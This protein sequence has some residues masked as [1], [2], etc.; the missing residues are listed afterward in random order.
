[1]IFTDAKLARQLEPWLERVLIV[2]PAH[3]SAKLLAELIKGAGGQQ[4]QIERDYAHAMAASS[5]LEPRLV[6]TDVGGAEL[7]GL[8]FVRDLRRSELACRQAVVVVL[9]AEAT[10]SVIVSARN[11]GV[12]EFLRKPFTA[13][14]LARRLEAAALHPRDWIEAVGYVGPD[15]RRFNSGDY[16]GPRKRRT[17]KAATPAERIEQAVRIAKAAVAGFDLDRAQAIRSL[18]VQASELKGLGATGG[19]AALTAAAVKLQG[20]LAAASPSREA[21]EA[22]AA[23]L[24]AYL[25]SVAAASP[26]AA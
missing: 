23:G 1:M 13:R 25:P 9:T 6:F 11:A 22:A 21:V 7:E 5:I 26:A 10:A 8:S 18:Q 3:A 19:D 12:H 15:R 20:A 4:I 14:D 2:E 17:D 24:W 16:K